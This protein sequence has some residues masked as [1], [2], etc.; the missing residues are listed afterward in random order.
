V[1]EFVEA[2]GGLLRL[3]LG[4]CRRPGAIPAK[5]LAMVP[6]AP[7]LVSAFYER[8]W[9]HGELDASAELLA[10]PFTFRG[11]LGAELHGREAFLDYVRSVRGALANYRC[12]ILECVSDGAR[13]FAKMRFSGRHVAPIRG[14]APSGMDV[15]WLG[16][17]LFHFDS[18]R[19]VALWVLGDLAA[20]DELL[21]LNAAL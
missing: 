21:R 9:N 12:E 4:W 16:A 19:I 8:I 6:P 14:F 17:A 15:H 11:S 18:G 2:G 7:P 3:V 20:L 1:R 13:A 5:L 10:E